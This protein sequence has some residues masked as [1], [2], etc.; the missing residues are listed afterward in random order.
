M[1]QHERRHPVPG[2]EVVFYDLPDG[3]EPAKK[4]LEGLDLKLLAKRIRNIELL[5]Q[6]RAALRMP[7]A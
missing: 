2:F 6:N 3:K 5:Q 1:K 7:Y 4:L